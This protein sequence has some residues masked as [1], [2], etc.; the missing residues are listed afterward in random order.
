MSIGLGDVIEIAAVHSF[1]G[2]DEVINVWHWKA[3]VASVAGLAEEDT[4]IGTLMDL[5]YST[6]EGNMPSVL[7]AT[8]IRWRNVTD[9]TPTRYINWPGPYLGGTNAG[10]SLPPGVSPLLIL[11]TGSLGRTGKKFM[12]P[13]CESQSTGGTLDGGALGPLGDLAAELLIQQSGVASSMELVSVVYSRTYGTSH[14]VISVK[15]S[16]NLAYQRRRRQGHGS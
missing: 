9:N 12:P 16:P 1:E 5:L 11:R 8:E 13:F 10:A 6:I 3:A 2:T 4:D 7:A 14:P 15:V